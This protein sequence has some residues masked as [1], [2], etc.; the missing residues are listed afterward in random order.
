MSEEP[1]KPTRSNRQPSEDTA[2]QDLEPAIAE[3]IRQLRIQLEHHN[4][5]YHSLDD[6][7][8]SD[9]EFDALLLR[10][11]SLEAEHQV[12]SADSPTQRVGGS[13][14]GEFTQVE[15]EIAMLSLDKVFSAADLNDFEARLKKRL[16]NEAEISYS[17]EPKI[18]GIAVSL[19][20]RDG[21]LERAATRGDGKTGENISHNV[22]TIPDI[23]LRLATA[24]PPKLLEVRGEIFIEKANFEK[25][26]ERAIAQGT[27]VFANPRNTAAG[28]VRQLNPKNAARVPLQMYCY[29][30]G[31]VDGIPALDQLSEVFN[32]LA[33]LGLPVNPD[34]AVNRGIDACLA[35]CLALLERRMDLAYE[36]DGVVIK[37]DEF[38]LQN[39]LG[40]NIRSPR[41]AMAYKFPAQE[42]TTTIEDVD[43][44]VGRTGT[45]TPVARLAPVFV[46][47]VTVSNA[48]LHNMDEIG[49]LGIRI[50]DTVL[51]RR[52]GDVI[53]KVV[54][55]AKSASEEDARDI[56]F[57]SS[58]PACGSKLEQDGEVLIRC[59]GEVICPAQKK[60]KFKHFTSRSAL[61]IEGLGAKLVEQLID[62][63]LVSDF[64]D[65]FSLGV[66]ELTALERMGS[67][68]A[69][70]LL[71]AIVKS[72]ATSLQ[73]FLFALGIREVGEATAAALVGHY[74][75]LEAII[76]AD[77]DSLETVPDVGPVVARH[78]V[79]FFSNT[80]NRTSLNKLLDAGIHWPSELP[81][82][83]EALPLATETWV[84][85][86]S[87]EAM[88]RSEAK[89]KLQALGAKVAGS[90][91]AKTT[92]VVAGPGAGSKL[93]KAE[94]LG[95]PVFTE[96]Q[97]LDLLA[98][99]GQ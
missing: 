85:T 2:L 31:V 72:K 6:P 83:V 87:L 58:C 94:S 45:I 91:S 97:L 29:S 26:N 63:N 52:A 86:G 51:I 60:E 9:A 41:W 76:A 7:E 44:Q 43:F 36:I 1:I 81:K 5:L 21:L 37:V 22:R 8:I 55:L 64:A 75:T 30:L 73:R 49:R 3:E 47:G 56:V 80:I 77:V 84:L 88:P 13:A 38:T 16:S 61:D 90:V 59:T 10:L 92:R 96:Q 35:Y 70:N 68:S 78:I 24:N 46:G 48:T 27:K 12:F 15:H 14:L 67:K 32:Y 18:D 93:D 66:D 23:P 57:P 79:D 40:T 50:G 25:L 17:C 19:L 20:Y 74:G 39:E 82:P 4:R 33:D 54:K 95:I 11:E 98:D 62:E 65:L 69:E 71:K 99:F 53:P 28:A 34:R 89:A 42:M